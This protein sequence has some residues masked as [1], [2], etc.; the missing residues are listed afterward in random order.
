MPAECGEA[1]RRRRCEEAA[2]RYRVY[3]EALQLSGFSRLGHK[4]IA[5]YLDGHQHHLRA[6]AALH[7][8]HATAAPAVIQRGTLLKLIGSSLTLSRW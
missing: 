4:L 7:N 8:T 5:M 2:H 1:E 3:W 6:P